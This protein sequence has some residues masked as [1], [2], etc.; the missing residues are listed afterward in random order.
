MSKSNSSKAPQNSGRRYESIWK[1]ISTAD[2]GVK[3]PVRTHHT[4]A[5]TLIQAVCKE[6]SRETS[7]KRKLGMR[8]AGKLVIEKGEPDDKGLVVIQ[9]SLEWDGRRL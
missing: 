9:F 3:V 4:A 1:A 2:V 5:K 6:K 7:E 8:F